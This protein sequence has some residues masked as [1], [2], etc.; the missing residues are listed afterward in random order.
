MFSEEEK[1]LVQES[2][3]VYLQVASQQ[4]APQMVEDLATSARAIIEKLSQATYGE[5]GDNKPTGISDEWFQSVCKSCD[6]LDVTGCKDNVT[7]KFPGKCDPILKFEM[8][9]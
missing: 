3:A 2:L 8:S 7:K 5:E 4:M 6:Q 1:Q 9:K